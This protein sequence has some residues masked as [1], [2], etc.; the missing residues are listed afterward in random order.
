MH[1]FG[2]IVWLGG[3]M[4]QNAVAMPVIQLEGDQAKSAMKKVN[5]RFIGFI[6]MS[7]WTILITGIILMLL[8]P[9]F[10]WFQYDNAWSVLLL[11]KQA[12][13]ILMVVYAFGYARMLSYL[14]APASNGGFDDT[15]ELYRHRVVQFRKVSIFLGIVAL[16]L[17]AAMYSAVGGM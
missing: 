3:L 5:K 1:V 13:F 14:E 4:F 2:V 12:L 17:S 11:C 6:W 8:S 10:I 16:L 9:R 15:A 7:V